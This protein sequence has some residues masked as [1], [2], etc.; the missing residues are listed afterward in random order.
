M[1][2]SP[3]FGSPI[4]EKR[5]LV[6]LALLSSLLG[7][8]LL[9]PQAQAQA[10]AI[11]NTDLTGDQRNW[12]ETFATG[13]ETNRNAN[14]LRISALVKHEQNRRVTA[15]KIDDD[16]DGSDDTS[17]GGNR[18]VTAQRPTVVDGYGYSRVT[19]E[20]R[21]PTNN[22]GMSCPVFGTRTRRTVK[23]VRIR[24]VLDNGTQTATTSSNI[25]FVASGNCLSAEDYPFLYERSQSASSI[26]TGQSVTFTYVGDDPDVTGQDDFDGIRWRAR[27]LSDGATTSPQTSCPNNGDNADKNLTVNFPDRGRW[28]IEAELLNNDCNESGDNMNPGYWHYIGAVDVNSPASSSPTIN[29]T[30]TRPQTNGNTT[31]TAAVADPADSAEG[32]V[33]EALEW[34]L[35][36]N[37]SNGV[38]GYEDFEQGNHKTGLT[39]AQRTRTI[40]TAGMEPGLYTVRARVGDNGALGGADNIRR[41]A[42]DTVQYLVNSPPTATSQSRSTMTEDPLELTL[43]G[44]DDDGDALTY[45]I[46]DPPDHGTLSGSGTER[47]YTPD[48]G[49]AGT[50]GFTY[51]VSDGF[52]GSAMA[53]VALRVDPDI[54]I[55]A[56]PTDIE[57]TRAAEF[58]FSSRATGATFEC[59]LDDGPYEACSSPKGYTDISDGS[60]LFRVRALAGT[61]TQPTEASA[62]FTLEAVPTVTIDSAPPAETDEISATFEFT[63]AEAGATVAPTTDC[64]LDGGE[65]RPCESPTRYTDLDDGEH[66]F[67]VRATDAFGKRATDTH[68]WAIDAIGSNTLIDSAPPPQTRETDATVTF[69]SPDPE[70]TFECSF[71]DGAFEACSSPFEVAGLSEGAH[72]FRARAVDAAGIVDPTP[73]SARWRVDLTPPES[74]IDA[75]PGSLTNDSTPTFEFSANEFNSTF[76]C[77]IDG[78]PFAGCSSPFTSPTLA[79]GEHTFDVLA[80][81]AAGNREQEATRSTFEVDL[82]AP[83]TRITSGPVEG[84]SVASD[85]ATLGFDSPDP[86]A[87][88]F[89]CRLDDEGWRP[90]SSDSSQ[91]YEGLAE[92][93]HVFTVRAVDR[94]GNVDSTP[95]TRSWSVDTTPP[96]TSIEGGPSGTVRERTA[97]FEL[98]ADDPDASFECSLDAAPFEPC[99]SPQAYADLSDGPHRFQARAIDSLGNVDPSPATRDW[100]IDSTREAPPAQ[101]PQRKPCNFGRDD[102]PGCGDPFLRARAAAAGPGADTGERGFGKLVL[103]ANGGKAELG[104]SRFWIPR[105]LRLEVLDDRGAR[106]GR[107]EMFGY[108]RKRTVGLRSQAGGGSM[109]IAADEPTVTLERGGRR[110]AIENLPSRVRRLRLA[111]ESPDLAVRTNDCGTRSWEAMLGDREGNHARVATQ[112]DVR[113]PKGAGR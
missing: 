6:L 51:R 63:A 60:H 20:Y 68:S 90:C 62:A 101:Q 61:G 34:D 22:T 19:Y 92:G 95:P 8:L 86:D 96:Q 10:P 18:S 69:S 41:T 2:R 48:D 38:N 5:V 65:F 42:T 3:G 9:A 73:A 4:V 56:A 30:A 13:G 84:S 100:T 17:S 83:G 15:I 64:K 105:G 104:S 80:I 1:S 91:T 113:C 67:V 106:L 78:A 26:N 32:G 37:T 70:A 85:S 25:R 16:W 40:N 75:G 52:G 33:A 71:D 74:A 39:S 110:I 66:T 76:E 108:S 36:G 23:P 58:E 27:R 43:N 28:V 77:S 46:T 72:T 31:I 57:G 79:E 21:H 93:R 82:T 111:L 97:S 99:G 7:I 107:L 44:Q 55:D 54:S 11:V 24:A 12:L 53:T 81:D 112:S 45:T 88:V 87:D 102:A 14:V 94:A 59:R 109:V 50:D 35:D 29:L 98:G 103:K 89:R 47:T 49:F